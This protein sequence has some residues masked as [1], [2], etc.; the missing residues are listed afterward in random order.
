VLVFGR[1]LG[2]LVV[3]AILY[4]A[5]GRREFSPSIFGKANTLVQV[6]AV[7]VVLLH[8]LI[9][10]NWVLTLKTW[11]LW[12]TMLLTV[13]SGLNYAWVAARRVAAPAATGHH[14]K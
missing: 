5:A 6:T 2:I 1:D 4:V 12:M 3:S 14:V 8:Q 13:V 10:A 11:A 7:A 9:A